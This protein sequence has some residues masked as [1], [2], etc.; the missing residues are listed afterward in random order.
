MAEP[1]DP[2]DPELAGRLARVREEIRDA[3][4]RAGRA[5][6]L[7]ALIVVTKFH[8]A[9][10]VRDL[11]ALG[12]RRFGESRHPESREKAAAVAGLLADSPAPEW[13][14]VG[15]IQTNKA[16][17]IAAY[18]SCLHAIDRPE[19]VNAL[20]SI[21]RPSPLDVFVQ[22]NLTDDA[23]RGGVDDAGLEPLVEQVL[24]TPTLRLRGL[25]AV[26]PLGD[27]PDHAFETVR[28][29]SERIR[30]IAPEATALSMGMSGDFRSAIS[31]GAT[32][33]R[34]GAAITGKRPRRP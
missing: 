21:S 10:L 5:D 11:I 31:Q 26:A 18:A 3:S 30:S 24:A 20:A 33:L 15:Q 14:F 1:G 22:V 7:P 4:A 6:D 8:P 29:R 16:R 32:H 28:R 13:H 27:D 17:Q 25:M 2:A 9:T 12:E 19:L 34:I 23:G